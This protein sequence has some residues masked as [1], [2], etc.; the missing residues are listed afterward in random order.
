MR[1]DKRRAA[2]N[3]FWAAAVD[4][5]NSGDMKRL[6]AIIS[7][8]LGNSEK[9]VEQ[10]MKEWIA[11]TQ[12]A[13]K[14]GKFLY[15]IMEEN[16]DIWLEGLSD[17]ARELWSAGDIGRRLLELGVNEKATKELTDAVN[18]RCRQT[19]I[20]FSILGDPDEPAPR[21]QAARVEWRD[22]TLIS[23]QLIEY[24]LR[25]QDAVK[26]ASRTVYATEIENCDTALRNT[27]LVFMEGKA[28]SAWCKLWQWINDYSGSNYSQDQRQYLLDLVPKQMR[29]DHPTDTIARF[30]PDQLED[31]KCPDKAATR[32]LAAL[33]FGGLDY[34]TDSLIGKPIAARS[35]FTLEQE[36]QTRQ[37]NQLTIL[38]GSIYNG[39][40]EVA[41]IT[42]AWLKEISS[43][44]AINS[45]PARR[46]TN[47]AV[48]EAHKTAISQKAKGNMRAVDVIVEGG[49]SKLC[50]N[51]GVAVNDR[52]RKLLRELILFLNAA[53][54]K[55]NRYE[56]SLLSFSDEPAAPGRPAILALSLQGALNPD[57]LNSLRLKSGDP[58]AKL[59]PIVEYPAKV[60]KSPK[61]ATPELDLWDSLMIHIRDN[62]REAAR[63]G[64]ITCNKGD[65]D[66]L[67]NASGMKARQ[68][69]KTI[70]GWIDKGALESNQ[71]KIK[72]TDSATWRFICK[73][74]N[75]E[76]RG[77]DAGLASSKRKR[78]YNSQKS[79]KGK[80]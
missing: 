26:F 17:V 75:L 22:Y 59:V 16:I 21:G 10:A 29:T 40:V 39:Q 73:G 60:S 56:S 51:I 63:T 36:V 74:G 8:G 3:K 47:W 41:T 52:N 19:V 69:D 42:D 44:S 30:K 79:K 76:L 33:W 50:E 45:Y 32:L 78:K 13:A 71:D 12:R 7:G 77:R 28:E 37:S 25:L 61:M 64:W 11:Q 53:R 57:W 2:R 66:S 38:D 54:F 9:S 58:L 6:R 5:Y 68:V 34:E 67:A 70:E 65:I 18:A 1:G 49:Y 15:D 48:R 23:L 35:Q 27:V 31:L 24:E 72:L 14:H 46:F 20:D 55:Y 62:A 43:T 4:A 80:K